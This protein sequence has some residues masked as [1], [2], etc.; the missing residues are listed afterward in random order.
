MN[1]Y[2]FFASFH[3]SSNNDVKLKQSKLTSFRLF[4]CR[5]SLADIQWGRKTFNQ[6]SLPN[7]E[8]LHLDDDLSG[9]KNA[10]TG[11]HPLP[12]K[13]QLDNLLN[14]YKLTKDSP[15]VVF[16]GV[17]LAFAAR[18]WLIFQLAGCNNV[19]IL[20]EGYPHKSNREFLPSEIW[21]TQN[22]FNIFL[23]PAL[24]Q[25][26]S[27]K[28]LN[29]SDQCLIDAR[30]S[31][32]FKGE[33]EPIDPVAGT[34]ANAKNVPWLDLK[35]AS[36]GNWQDASWHKERYSKIAPT[37]QSFCHFCGSGVTAIPNLISALLAFN[38]VD[39]KSVV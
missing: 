8:Y 28:Q 17:E 5:F 27:I 12:S 10:S 20:F 1:F 14:R 35:S 16:D 19:K 33:Q 2:D 15:I 18:A 38:Q 21:I 31:A 3:A 34:I 9:V 29:H 11:R 26:V 13:A 7:A 25:L 24:L 30:E 4:D 6:T 32:R 39:R 36:I 22:P 37:F 23:E